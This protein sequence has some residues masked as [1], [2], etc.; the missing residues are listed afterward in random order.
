MEELLQNELNTKTLKCLGRSGGCV[1]EGT[2]YMTDLGKIFVKFNNKSGAK[3]MFDGE[4]VSLDVMHAMDVV[5]VPKPIK[6]I[7]VPEGGAMIAMEY[8]DLS[9][10]LS[11]CSAILGEQ[12][13]RLHLLNEELGKKMKNSENSVHKNPHYKF[14]DKFGFDVTT[15]CGYLPQ[16]NTWQDDWIKFYAR[17]IEVQME[18]LD[19][20][21]RD[22]E[23]RELWSQILA[24]L[25][26]LFEGSNIQPALLHGD[27]WAGNVAETSQ[28]PVMFDPA[29]FYGHSEFDLSISRL[30]GGFSQSFFDAYHKLIPQ[31]PGYRERLELYK[32]FHYINHW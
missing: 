30:F 24:K 12:L 32:F 21:Y 23:A 11:K 29:C 31:A 13:A 18:L 26:L 22:K 17:K 16:D 5:K 14:V 8:L 15:C 19:K 3:L 7:S 2:S 10:G 27:L 25:P 20:K 1:N 6:V 4:L 28:G 9:R